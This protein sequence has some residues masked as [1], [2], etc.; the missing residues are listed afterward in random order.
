MGRPLST[1]TR[2]IPEPRSAVLALLGLLCLVVGVV[3]TGEK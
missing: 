3:R 1:S 2:F